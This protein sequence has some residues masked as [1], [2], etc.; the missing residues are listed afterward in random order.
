M[1]IGILGGTFD[2]I[3]MGHLILAEQCRDQAKLDQVWVMPSAH[4]PHKADQPVTRFE[5]RCEM[6]EL[7]IAGHPVFRVERIEKE[8]PPPSY[9]AETLA[10][11]HRRH[12]ANEFLL[13]MGSDQ[14]PDLPGWY[15]PKR[16]VEQAGLVVVARPGVPVWTADILAK[17]LGLDVSAIQLGTVDCP[18]I[19]I[20]SRE[21]RR[22]IAE[23]KSIRYLV[24]RAVEEYICDRKLYARQ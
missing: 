24:P 7:A 14:L 6:I 16:V 1:R 22:S 20:S 5:Q 3:H 23:G 17:A 11:L 9:T 18:L 8:L 15:Q 2:P 21:L 10:E 4:P 12:P 19:E 13:L